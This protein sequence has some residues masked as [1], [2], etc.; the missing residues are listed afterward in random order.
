MASNRQTTLISETCIRLR[1][2]I[3]K[4]L[5]NTNYSNVLSQVIDVAVLKFICDTL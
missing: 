3:I 5:Q 4:Q 1:F 2:I